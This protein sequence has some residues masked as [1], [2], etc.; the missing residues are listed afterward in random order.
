MGLWVSGT[1]LGIKAQHSRQAVDSI[2]NVVIVIRVM[3]LWVSGTRL[4]IKNSAQQ[5]G[6]HSKLSVVFV[7][8]LMGL[9]MSGGRLDNRAQQ[10]QRRNKATP[11]CH[12]YTN[13]PHPRMQ[14]Q[15]HRM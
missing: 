13:D 9:W 7:V 12:P 11:Q 1:R 8:R 5:A 10:Q 4:G 15:Q 14:L 6:I 3:G 2:L